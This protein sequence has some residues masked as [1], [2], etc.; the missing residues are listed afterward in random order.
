MI[1]G[2]T[3]T[4]KGWTTAQARAVRGCLA[5]LPAGAIHG[6]AEGADEEFDTYLIEAG[7][8]PDDILILP[9]RA[10]RCFEPSGQPGTCCQ[11][12]FRATR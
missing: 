8:S 9:G 6:G 10:R 12:T 11:A 7:M 3:G 4:R 5:S 1:L 2:F